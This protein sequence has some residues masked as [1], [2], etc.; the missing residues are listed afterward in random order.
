MK[1]SELKNII[2][3][4]ITEQM[5]MMDEESEIAKKAKAQGLTSMGFGRWGKPGPGGKMTVTM[6]SNKGKLVPFSKAAMQQK[7][8]MTFGRGTNANTMYSPQT[9]NPVAKMSEPGKVQRLDPKRAP[10]TQ[11]M[12]NLP[13]DDLAPVGPGTNRP[14][15]RGLSTTPGTPVS[16]QKIVD[17]VTDLFYDSSI[18]DDYG[19]YDTPIPMADFEKATGITRAAAKYYAD[20]VDD[21]EVPFGY[22]ADTDSV[23]INDTE[24][25]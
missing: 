6:I 24:D 11:R 15:A 17:K 4:M 16:G 13:K 10:E 12:R 14:F 1:L 20:T 22:D 23:F 5:S 9:R 7:T 3:E 19:T 21:Y 2:R 25:V 8:G 18:A